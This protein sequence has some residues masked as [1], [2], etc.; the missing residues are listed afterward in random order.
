[1]EFNV[2]KCKAVHYEKQNVTCKLWMARQWRK[3]TKRETSTGIA[4][5]WLKF[6]TALSTQFRSYRAFKVELC[7]KYYN[8]ISINI[9]GKIIEKY[10]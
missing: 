6:F 5:C 4:D 3:Q 8:L 1:M 7:Y 9:Y 2:P 10:K